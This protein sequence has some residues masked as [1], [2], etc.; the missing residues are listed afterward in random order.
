M[1]RL[2][3]MPK[4]GGQITELAFDP[5]R[6]R[7]GFFVNY[8]HLQQLDDMLYWTR[9]RV[10][11]ADHWSIRTM[12]KGGGTPT[13]IFP[14]DV[15]INPM[16]LDGWRAAGGQIAAITKHPL[17][18]SIVSS[19]QL[20]GFDT[21]KAKWAELIDIATFPKKLFILA[22]DDTFVYV[23]GVT[24]AGATEIGRISPFD[25]PDSYETLY[26]TRGTDADL[27]EIGAVDKTAL[28][29]WSRKNGGSDTLNALPIDGGNPARYYTLP[30][31]SGLTADGKNIYWCTGQRIYRAPATGGGQ[32][33]V[34]TKGVFRVATVGGLAIDDTSIYFA[35]QVDGRFAI[36]QVPK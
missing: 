21:E 8:V 36:A 20:A 32:P 5:L 29:F 14:E 18:L 19:T 6:D 1:N 4:G 34:V 31:G 7:Q 12:G 26:S 35:Q 27:A 23:R 15:G 10:G 11:F 2:R 17:P 33:E 25:G 3:S 16:Y 28:Y 13:S 9:Q 24:A 30:L 22:G